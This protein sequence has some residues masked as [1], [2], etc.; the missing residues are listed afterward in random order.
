MEETDKIK[1][2]IATPTLIDKP[3]PKNNK[4]EWEVKRAIRFGGSCVL[5]SNKI[6]IFDAHDN[7]VPSL[8]T[9]EHRH[10]LRWLIWVGWFPHMT[11]IRTVNA[12]TKYEIGN[13]AKRDAAVFVV[14]NC[15]GMDNKKGPV[16]GP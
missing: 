12:G 3:K 2:V 15:T 7:Y 14:D 4:L 1:V 13:K 10:T 6:D 9:L 8:L 16:T 11:N 5:E